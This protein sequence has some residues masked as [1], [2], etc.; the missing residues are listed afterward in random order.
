M[1]HVITIYNHDTHPIWSSVYQMTFETMGRT[2][3]AY[4]YSQDI[5]KYHIPVIEK[6]LDK[7][8]KYKK[9][10]YSQRW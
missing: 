2:N 6:I 4:T 1:N 7:Q 9:Y 8:S 10:T 5:T 3:G